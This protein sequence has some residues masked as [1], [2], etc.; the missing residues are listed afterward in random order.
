MYETIVI[1]KRTRERYNLNG[2]TFSFHYFPFQHA[3]V[4]ARILVY[5]TLTIYARGSQSL[6]YIKSTWGII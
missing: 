6:V 3:V 2:T 1:I 4:G 5:A